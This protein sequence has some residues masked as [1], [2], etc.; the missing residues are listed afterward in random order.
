[1]IDTEG[2][3]LTVSHAIPRQVVLSGVKTWIE[4]AVGNKPGRISVWPLLWF[5]SESQSYLLFVLGWLRRLSQTNLSIP[6]LLW[7]W[8]LIVAVK[9]KLECPAIVVTS[10]VGGHGTSHSH[11]RRTERAALL[12][13][14]AHGVHLQYEA[15][16]WFRHTLLDGLLSSHMGEAE[17]VTQCHQ[18]SL[19]RIT[20]SHM[21]EAVSQLHHIPPARV[22]RHRRWGRTRL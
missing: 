17:A 8:C 20:S 21:E 9:S 7:P 19:A 12:L 18:V 1:M 14:E 16:T 10:L 5:L 6:K 4:Q 22:P 11:M 2:P 15:V 3:P 13:S